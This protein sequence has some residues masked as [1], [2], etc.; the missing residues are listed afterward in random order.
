LRASCGL[1]QPNGSHLR[2]LALTQVLPFPLDA[3]P[4]V[5]AYYTLRK[6]AERHA[7]RLVSFRRST[8][9]PEALAHLESFCDSVITVPIE[10]AKLRDALDLAGSLLGS[11]PFLIRRDR[12]P[13][14]DR[15][16]QSAMNDRINRIDAIHADQLWM[17][18]YALRA[19]RATPLESRPS[20]VLDQH[21]AVMQIPRRLAN[22]ERNPMKRAILRL[23]DQKLRRYEPGLCSAFDRV[24]WVT[25]EDRYAVEAVA[26]EP[27]RAARA[28]DVIPIC[29]SPEDTPSLERAHGARRVTFLGGL[30]WPPNAEGI[31]WFAREIWPRVR[32]LFPDA[33]LTVIGKDPPAALLNLKDSSSVEL[34]GYVDDPTPYLRETGAFIVPLLSGG[35]MRVKILD[36]W[37]WGL[38]VVSTRIGA[39]G[40]AAVDGENALLADSASEFSDAVVRLLDKPVLSE[41]IAQGGR[42]TAEREYDW[43]TR[44]E[45][46]HS[47]Y[48][49]L[50][51]QQSEAA[52]VGVGS[53]F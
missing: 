27:W 13:E 29:V 3:G 4:K 47:V 33:I 43:R 34:T 48:E 22:S 20:L 21:N 17:A 44:Y 50:A 14:M 46:W 31:A 24:V 26:A 19:A 25:E 53:L 41:R 10:R 6:L 49:Q 39:E 37:C 51:T 23:E 36:A 32:R 7:V 2:I 9:S 42:C 45:S 30:H 15:A 1:A 40:I 16:I 28:S 5:R 18:P 12:R 35:G 38:P 52:S 8:D 11:T